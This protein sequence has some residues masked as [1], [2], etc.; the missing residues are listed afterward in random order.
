MLRTSFD[1]TAFSLFFLPISLLLC[2]G[3][4][5]IDVSFDIN[6]SFEL[7][8]A[9]IAGGAKILID[10]SSKVPAAAAN[11]QVKKATL[12]NFVFSANCDGIRSSDISLS[13]DIISV[14]ASVDGA[15][16]PFFKLAMPKGISA[17]QRDPVLKT[18]VEFMPCTNLFDVGAPPFALNEE[19]LKTISE[20]LVDWQAFANNIKSKP[21]LISINKGDGAP[22]GDW[23][24]NGNVQATL[25]V[26]FSL[27]P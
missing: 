24:I 1:K 19:Q 9:D 6:E 22:A 20:S 2:V 14:D 25:K 18:V 16:A 10:L 13:S 8:N 5:D 23:S 26:T 17:L 21:L 27:A 3:C 11:L 4:A 12:T 15:S 7:Q